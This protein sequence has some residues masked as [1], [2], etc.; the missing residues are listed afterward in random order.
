MDVPDA[1]EVELRRRLGKLLEVTPPAGAPRP[2]F[3]ARQPRGAVQRRGSFQRH[4]RR[5]TAVSSERPWSI[6]G[7]W[8]PFWGYSRYPACRGTARLSPPAVRLGV[9]NLPGTYTWS[10]K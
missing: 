8:R 9:G 6:A 10:R 3:R 4:K 1:V 5:A 7:G 2:A